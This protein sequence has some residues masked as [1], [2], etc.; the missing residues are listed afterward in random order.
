MQ[1]SVSSSVCL[2][3]AVVA[4]TVLGM[5]HALAAQAPTKV[6]VRVT[7]NDAKIIGSNVGG[8]RVTIRD[9]ETGAVLA[10]GVQRG[11]TGD[12]RRIMGTRERGGLV[13][14]TEGAAGFLAELHL[15]EPTRVVITGEGPLGTPHAVQTTSRS[16]LVVPGR[17]VL[18][19]GVILELLGFTV[20][21]QSPD[22]GEA[23][24]AGR[25]FE[26]R[27]KV[28]MLCG[29]PTEPGGLWDSGEYEILVRAV[30]ENEVV[31][32]WEMAYAG[33]TSHYAADITL[34][35]PG[36]VELQMLAMDPSKG[37]FGMTTRRVVVEAS[38]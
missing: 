4:G 24:S 11:S 26:V 22:D 18:G 35:A 34:E 12:T 33:E 25:P 23:V 32:E 16:L 8:A 6:L 5:P 3:A 13:Y 14:D 37:N 10:E 29:C 20:E 31:G 21:L 36:E 28:T 17:D 38:P 1:R 7:S 19:E 15:A 27:G 30:R 2:L 9:A